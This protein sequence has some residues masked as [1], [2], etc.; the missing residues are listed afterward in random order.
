M[1]FLIGVIVMYCASFTHSGIVLGL[2]PEQ[3]ELGTDENGDKKAYTDCEGY[4][5]YTEAKGISK[6]DADYNTDAV[7][8]RIQEILG[9]VLIGNYRD[10]LDCLQAIR[11]IENNAEKDFLE[12]AKDFGELASLY[13][14]Q[15]SLNERWDALD[16]KY[17]NN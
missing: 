6:E 10:E 12:T 13:N 7:D 5:D 1:V 8:Q 15:Q 14:E 3:E 17:G 16:Q 2:T 11:A 9:M 4:E